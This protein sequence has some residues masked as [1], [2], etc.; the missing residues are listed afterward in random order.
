MT[1]AA[2]GIGRE[3]AVLLADRGWRVA[4]VD[5]EPSVAEATKCARSE[6]ILPLEGDVTDEASMCDVV[7]TALEHFGRIDGVFAN[8]ARMAFGS[9]LDTDPDEWRDILEVNLT[10][11]YTTT[12]VCL[13][14]MLEAG[15]GVVLATSSDATVRTTRNTAAYVASK[16]AVIGL[17]RSIAVDY[18][19]QG[20]RANALIPGVTDTPG[21]RDIYSSPGMSVRESLGKAAALSPLGRTAMPRDVARVAAFLFSDEAAFITGSSITVDGGMTIT[22][23]AD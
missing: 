2:S 6:A 16:H 12:R 3:T 15:G 13:P 9:L 8:A 4:A 17:T 7:A 1:G 5:I 22:Y 18:G 10:G 23:G 21:V 20:I 14:P 11:V 19:N